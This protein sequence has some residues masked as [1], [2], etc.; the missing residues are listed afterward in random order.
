LNYYY[1][2]SE[3]LDVVGSAGYAFGFEITPLKVN[4]NYKILDKISANMGM[5]FIYDPIYTYY[6]RGQLIEGTEE[7]TE[8]AI[9]EFGINFGM[10]YK[11]TSTNALTGN[12]NSLKNDTDNFNGISF[13]LSFT[14]IWGATIKQQNQWMRVD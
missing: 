1:N 2:L 5:Y 8:P 9:S 10:S 13:G 3:K 6:S 12:Y 4:F 11:L 14:P 7:R